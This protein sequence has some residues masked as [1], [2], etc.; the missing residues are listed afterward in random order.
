M[1]YRIRHKDS[2]AQASL[3]RIAREEVQAAARSLDTSALDTGDA[4][5]G[6][7]V[8]DG[9]GRLRWRHLGVEPYMEVADVLAAVEELGVAP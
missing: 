7:F 9:A 4:I 3:R 2:R 5:H 1:A 8:L 6:V